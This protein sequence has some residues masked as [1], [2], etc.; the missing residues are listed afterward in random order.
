MTAQLSHFIRILLLVA[1]LSPSLAIADTL[2]GKVIGVA[3]GDTVTILDSSNRQW[4]IRLMGI[5]A[6]EKRMPFG[7]RAKENLSSLVFN[8]Q[9]VVEYSKQDKYGRTVGKILVSG[10]DANLAQVK[11]GLAWH[12]KKYQAEQSFEDRRLYAEAETTAKKAKIGLW[13]EPNPIPPWDWRKQ[14][15]KKK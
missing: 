13:S 8:K 3:D 2:E 15:R 5:D 7:Q 14:Q 9:V 6:P 11:E 1:L 4:K 12:Y 10:V